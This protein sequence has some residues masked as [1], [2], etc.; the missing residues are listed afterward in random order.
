MIDNDGSKCFLGDNCPGF[1]LN[2]NT[3]KLDK[4]ETCEPN[5]SEKELVRYLNGLINKKGSKFELELP[6]YLE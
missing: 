4:C 6:S 3:N 5:K 1:F 2:G